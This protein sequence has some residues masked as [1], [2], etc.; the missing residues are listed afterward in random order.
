MLHRFVR[1]ESGMTMGLVIIMILLIGVL[2]AGLLTFVS[3]DLNTVVEENKGQRAFELADAGVGAAKRQ[4]TSD[5]VGNTT[6]NAHYDGN[7]AP[8]DDDICGS[9]DIQWSALRCDDPDGLTL[10]D[11]DL[12]GE[13]GTPDSVIV[14][15]KY[16]S[17]PQDDYQ[18]ISMGTYGNAKRKIEATFKGISGAPL[19]GNGL[20]HPLYYTPSAIMIEGPLKLNQISLFADKDIL[21][22]GI[23]GSGSTQ[24]QQTVAARTMFKTDYESQGTG[25]LQRAGGDDELQDWDTTKNPPFNPTGTWNTTP[26]LDFYNPK[27]QGY[28]GWK[29]PGFASEGK[30]CGYLATDSATG[31]CARPSIADGVYGYDCT[32]GPSSLAITGCP[33]SPEPRGNALAFVSKE[34]NLVDGSYP[35]NPSGTISYP[36]PRPTPKPAGL[37]S[38]AVKQETEEA[39]PATN[40]H[41]W[42]VGTE[43]LPQWDKLLP[44]CPV[45]NPNNCQDRV[46]FIDADGSTLDFQTSNSANNKGVLVVWCG[47]LVQRAK[48]QGIILNLIGD[49][50]GFGVSSCAATDVGF[51]GTYRNAGSLDQNNP[52]D[53]SGWLY[54]QGGTESKAGIELGPNSSIGFLPGADWSLLSDILEYEG[55]A[56]TSFQLKGWRELYQ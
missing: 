51:P 29:K 49:G 23:V 7:G 9:D 27:P 21:I 10:E 47:R 53:F 35:L 46:L 37:K 22:Q 12:D 6:C 38:L 24:L 41:Y 2:G 50:N 34:P 1:D 52:L 20:G 42:D 28:P 32:T 45:T 14:T 48:F 15:I 33:D 40:R 13:G 30:I 8:T 18:V 44:A 11:L 5:C 31:T 17:P 3:R 54:A 26:R 16:R 43:G 4:L 25:T 19:G 39:N 56:P 36:F 55:A